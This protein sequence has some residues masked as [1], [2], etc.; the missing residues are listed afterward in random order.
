MSISNRVRGGGGTGSEK[1]GI[2]VV[3]Y[4]QNTYSIHDA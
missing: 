2:I 4:T 1:I 3:R